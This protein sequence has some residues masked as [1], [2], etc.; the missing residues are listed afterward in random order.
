MAEHS[1]GWPSLHV[2][3]S[4]I[5]RKRGNDSLTD[6]TCE[7]KGQVQQQ[8]EVKGASVVVSEPA[9]NWDEDELMRQEGVRVFWRR[10]RNIRR[11]RRSSGIHIL[12]NH[13]RGEADNF[14]Q[15]RLLNREFLS[16]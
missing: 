11:A 8:P 2:L 1:T 13:E 15:F 5:S 9:W 7:S 10:Q 14:N 3:G 16:L 6:G 12:G 4:E